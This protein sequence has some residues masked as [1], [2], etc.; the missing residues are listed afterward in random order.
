LKSDRND[1][2]MKVQN[3]TVQRLPADSETIRHN[4]VDSGFNCDEREPGFYADIDNECQVRIIKS[5]KL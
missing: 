4:I 1:E 2:E 3:P 5:L